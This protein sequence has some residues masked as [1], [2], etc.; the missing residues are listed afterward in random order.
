MVSGIAE[1]HQYFAI[2]INIQQLDWE[3]DEDANFMKVVRALTINGFNFMVTNLLCRKQKRH[4]E[5]FTATI[6]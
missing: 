5:Q 2:Y 4:L 3:F 6:P 1:E